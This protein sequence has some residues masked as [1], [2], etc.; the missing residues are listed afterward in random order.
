MEDEMDFYQGLVAHPSVG[1]DEG[2]YFCLVI[3]SVSTN[4]S[5]L[6]KRLVSGQTAKIFQ[7]AGYNFKSVQ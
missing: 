6:L 7:W 2:W 1:T 3:L 5:Y 4:G